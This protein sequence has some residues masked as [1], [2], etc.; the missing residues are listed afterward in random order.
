PKEAASVPKCFSCEFLE[1]FGLTRP[2]RAAGLESASRKASHP[3]LEKHF[4]PLAPA[5]GRQAS[6]LG[7]GQLSVAWCSAT[8]GASVPKCFSSA[9][10]EAS[11]TGWRCSA[12]PPR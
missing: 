2:G 9:G 1:A 8:E 10:S 5:H 4:V 7:D 12:A 11:C 6:P 3:E